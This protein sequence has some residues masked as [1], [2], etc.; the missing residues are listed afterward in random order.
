MFELERGVRRALLQRPHPRVD[1]AAARESGP[2]GDCGPLL[3]VSPEIARQPVAPGS[4]GAVV[5]VVVVLL[6]TAEPAPRERG[7]E[8]AARA[9]S[10][11]Y[12][13]PICHATN[14]R[15]SKIVSSSNSSSIASSSSRC[16]AVSSG[17]GGVTSY[18]AS[19]CR[20][21]YRWRRTS[22]WSTAPQLAS[23]AVLR[24]RV[25]TVICRRPATAQRG[26]YRHHARARPAQ[27]AAAA[28]A[29]R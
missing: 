7:A 23:S 21:T 25:T 6:L 9:A 17:S 20:K 11:P 22:T 14:R 3:A 24:S 4:G 27:R 16:A 12:S 10:A 28:Q 18:R 29:A 5:L 1:A 19:L 13:R 15:N 26:T 2:L 8:V